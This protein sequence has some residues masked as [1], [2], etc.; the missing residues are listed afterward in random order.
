[1]SWDHP[2]S[3]PSGSSRRLLI[4]AIHT[5]WKPIAILLFVPNA[6]LLFKATGFRELYGP[7]AAL[8][9]LLALTAAL[10]AVIE[11]Q[12]VL[13][14]LGDR[15]QWLD[16]RD[17]AARFLVG[18]IALAF[19][20]A[21][22]LAYHERSSFAELD[23]A[24]KK[25]TQGLREMYTPEVQAGAEAIRKVQELKRLR[26]EKRAEAQRAATQPSTRQSAPSTRPVP[27]TRPATQRG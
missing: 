13:W 1:M 9:A 23:A 20:L 26:E 8:G 25:S 22:F 19:C 16:L 2:P 11:I 18:G 10:M 3:E 15:H 27:A 12:A 21:G 14:L 17:R 6:L 24:D 7:T 4:N 5:F